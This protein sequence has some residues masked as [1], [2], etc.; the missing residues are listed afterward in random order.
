MQDWSAKAH[1]TLEEIVN[2]LTE[3]ERLRDH[4][5]SAE[6]AGALADAAAEIP[7]TPAAGE[8]WSE[9]R[10]EGDAENYTLLDPSPSLGP[11]EPA[12]SA[13]HDDFVAGALH[14]A[15]GAGQQTPGPT[16]AGF[17]DRGKSAETAD[18]KPSSFFSL[19]SG[20][21][22]KPNQAASPARRLSLTGLVI[23][24][25]ASALALSNFV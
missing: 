5:V 11:A 7:Q 25:A 18:H 10:P 22:Q 21:Q 13:A 17:L 9:L 19:L 8:T 1:E 12:P 16:A 15:Q 6:P 24:A 14:A 23:L 2:K 20:G 4:S 3:L